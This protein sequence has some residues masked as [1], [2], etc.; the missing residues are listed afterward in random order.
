MS[1]R[2]IGEALVVSPEDLR[3]LSAILPAQFNIVEERFTKI[4][5]ELKTIAPKAKDFLYFSAVM[6][7]AA[8]AALLDDS[9]VLRKDANGDVLVASWTKE[10]DSWKW[11]CSDIN[12]LPYKN[13]N[14][15]IFPEEELVKAHKDWV[16]KPLCLDHKSNSVDMIRGVVVDT[17]YDWPRRRVVAL[18]ALDKITYPDL[19][20]KVSSKYATSVS[21]GTAVGRAICTDCGNVARAEMDFCDHMRNKSCYGEINVDLKPIELSIVVNG[22]DPNARIRHIVASAADSIAGYVADKEKEVSKLV[23][24]EI[25]S[26]STIS[27]IKKDLESAVERLKALAETVEEV[28]EHEEAEV[29]GE[30]PDEYK[31]LSGDK[32]AFKN[33]INIKLASISQQLS[34]LQN[35]VDQLANSEETNM[36]MKSKAYHQGGGG[37][38]DPSTLPYEKEDYQTNRDK[39]DKQMVGQ[40]VDNT[41][42]VDGMHLGYSSYGETE[43]ARKK[44]LQRMAEDR[45]LRR[46]QAVDRAKTAYHQGGGGVNDPST[47]PYEKEDYQTNRDKN[48]KQMVGAKPFPDVGPVDGLYPGDKETKEKLSRATLTAKFIKS[49]HPDGTD[50]LGQ[51]RWQV[52]AADK[53]ILTAT[54]DELTNGRS[55][56][57]YD[58]VASKVFGKKILGMLRTDSFDKVKGILKGAQGAPP[59]APMPEAPMPEA[60]PEAPMAGEPEVDAGGS[61]DP[62]E[63]LPELLTQAENVLA[64][65]RRAVDALIEEPSEEL[66]GFDELAEEMPTKAKELLTFQ[67]KVGGAITVGM[68][69]AVKELTDHVEELRMSKHIYDNSEKVSAEKLNYVDKLTVDACEETKQTLANCY[70][71]MEAFVK[72]A[73]GTKALLKRAQPMLSDPDVGAGGPGAGVPVDVETTPSQEVLE[74]GGLGSTEEEPVTFQ[75]MLQERPDSV[76]SKGPVARMAPLP[77]PPGAGEGV[78]YDAPEKAAPKSR[79]ELA[80]DVVGDMVPE[81]PE[82][83][84]PLEMEPPSADDTNYAEIGQDGSLTLSKEELAGGALAS[85]VN[86]LT[87][88]SEATAPNLSTKE[89]RAAYR[90]KLAQKGL[91][92]SPMLQEAHPGG[93]E[94]TQLDNKPQKDLAKV[95][96]LEEAHKTHMDVAT[97]PPKVRQAA[98]EIHRLVVSGRIDPETDF[99]ALIANGLDSDAVKYWK[100]YYAQGDSD[101]SQFAAELVKEHHAKKAAVDQQAYEV[102]ISRSYELA[103]DMV[104]RGMISGERSA[105]SEQVKEIMSFDDNGFESMKRFVERQAVAK[106]ASMPRVGILDANNVTLPAPPGTQNDLADELAGLWS[107]DNVSRR[108]SF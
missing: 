76:T 39:N 37:V 46:K 99:D 101:S 24:H 7:H 95:E 35:N 106:Q 81:M 38:N 62:K 41:G 100:Q 83:L 80:R 8:E 33:E 94:T 89:G 9:G 12:I 60:M 98:E 23:L 103:Y 78:T 26:E 79:E 84:P 52:Y 70:K 5:E 6:M 14:N 92:F 69:N 27:A 85:I 108:M 45:A 77:V 91:K 21:M 40:G 36:T 68:K 11:V 30:E 105:V 65:I 31:E 43:E 53:L 48:D 71:L 66:E 32:E 17:Y 22:A 61:G 56:L 19:A 74:Y 93:G 29:S 51:C 13:S 87:V 18:C 28:E 104:S 102:K 20:R 42:P 10:N 90:E 58:S 4:A 49:A 82:D 2:K 3:P 54:V 44:R 67:K 107:G 59:E 57:H 97:A 73:N 72:Y 96:T 47:L 63:Q 34:R 86:E 50:N 1:F 55:D 15:D 16:G 75:E 25:T 64:D 88:E